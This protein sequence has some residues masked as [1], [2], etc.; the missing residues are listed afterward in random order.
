[1][2]EFADVLE[3]AL[4]KADI[5]RSHL[6]LELNEN[7]LHRGLEYVRQQM[8]AIKKCGIRFSL[9]DFGTGDSSLSSLNMLPFD[10]VKID[11]SFVSSIEN[12]TEN[13]N[14]I[15]GILSVASA[16]K[17]D[18]V[19]EHVSSAYQETY[20]RERGCNRFQGY[21]Y[22]PP[23]SLGEF[24]EMAVQEQNIAHLKERATA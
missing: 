19:A 2:P 9:D 21:H 18:T 15:E 11:G 16:L 1:M 4:D 10:E 24:N 17:L 12:K 7:V 5:K 20:L 23:F 22:S 3:A 14:L 6:T 8:V 13:R